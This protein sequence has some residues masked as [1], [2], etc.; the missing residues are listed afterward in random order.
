MLET[1]SANGSEARLNDNVK[2]IT[3]KDPVTFDTF[4]QE[5]K[6]VWM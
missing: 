1:Q 2:Q 5:N 3:G 4:A 6:A